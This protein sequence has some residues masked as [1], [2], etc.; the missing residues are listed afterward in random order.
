MKSTQKTRQG[1]ELLAYNEANIAKV[2]GLPELLGSL[3]PKES[4]SAIRVQ[5]VL[6][7]LAV[8]TIERSTQ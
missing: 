8:S 4:A 3:S 1:Q 5:A 6:F 2:E 7:L